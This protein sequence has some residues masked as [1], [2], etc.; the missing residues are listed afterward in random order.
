M[1]PKRSG[2]GGGGGGGGGSAP[3]A[4]AVKVGLDQRGQ[5]K[6]LAVVQ[7]SSSSL[8]QPGV[9]LDSKRLA[10]RLEGLFERLQSLG[11]QDGHIERAMKACCLGGGADVSLERLLDWLCL[12]LSPEELPAQFN[13]AGA[14]EARRT[15]A[16]RVELGDVGSG[17]LGKAGGARE[18]EYDVSA[19]V[20]A[21]AAKGKAAGWGERA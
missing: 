10:R 14:N 17:V 9:D 1:P 3:S 15:A 4:G 19:V 13:D 11:F 16:A 8:G 2:N 18:V 6:I 21:Q 7:Q 5:D 20:R 12:N